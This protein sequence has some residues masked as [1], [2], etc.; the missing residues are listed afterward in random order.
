MVKQLESREALDLDALRDLQALPVASFG[1]VQRRMRHRLDLRLER[2]GVTGVQFGLLA[3]VAQHDGIAQTALQ[4]Q[5][6]IEGA[7]L[8]QLLQ[9]LERDGW[10][11]RSCD[12]QD[13]RRQRV[14]LTAKGQELLPAIAAEVAQHRAEIQHGLSTEDLTTLGRLLARLEENALA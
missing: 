12:P 7:T 13:R 10:L 6:A 3:L 9:R 5:L 8:T 1:R 14:W 2:Y 4:Q 11:T